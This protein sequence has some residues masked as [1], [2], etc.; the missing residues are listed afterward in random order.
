MGYFHTFIP[1]KEK[2]YDNYLRELLSLTLRN[3]YYAEKLKRTFRNKN[4]DSDSTGKE[5]L[6]KYIFH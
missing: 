3:Q 1:F 2:I 6:I 4:D 5:Y